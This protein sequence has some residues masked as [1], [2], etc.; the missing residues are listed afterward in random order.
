MHGSY[1]NRLP[2][3]FRGTGLYGKNAK[4]I[5]NGARFGHY[6]SKKVQSGINEIEL[7]SLLLELLMVVIAIFAWNDI[8]IVS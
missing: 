7:Q 8:I 3:V 4:G 6:F 5:A 2:G 1:Q